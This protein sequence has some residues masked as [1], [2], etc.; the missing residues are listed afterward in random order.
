MPHPN[1]FGSHAYRENNAPKIY[2]L[3]A[4]VIEIDT[5]LFSVY[6][7][8]CAHRA[9]QQLSNPEDKTDYRFIKEF[10]RVYTAILTS[11]LSSLAY[12]QRFELFQMETIQ[13]LIGAYDIDAVISHAPKLFN[14]K[15]EKYEF[16]NTFG[17]VGPL[18]GSECEKTLKKMQENELLTPCHNESTTTGQTFLLVKSL[19]QAGLLTST[20]SLTTPKQTN[21]INKMM[22][23]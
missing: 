18:A 4:E 11:P 21:S 6:L 14:T 8:R 3:L 16:F 23:Q 17:L 13:H 22:P 1:Q 20:P 19:Q 12:R 7:K 10:I 5:D 9:I 15:K 2:K